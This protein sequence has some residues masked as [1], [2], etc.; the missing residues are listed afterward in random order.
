MS[1]W[2]SILEIIGDVTGK[3]A[4]I[5]D[6]FTISVGTLIDLSYKL[7]ELGANKIIGCISHLLI[8]EK[9]VHRLNKSNIDMLIST[10]SINNPYVSLSHKIK[11]ISVAPLFA[12]AILRI[13]NNKSI[14]P[15]FNALPQKH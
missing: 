2:V 10:D 8:N 14:S 7:K 3:N 6:D 4:V 12:E 1:V 13:H 9:G 5:V 15:L 11:V